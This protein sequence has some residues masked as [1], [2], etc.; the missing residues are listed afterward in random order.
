MGVGPSRGP[1]KTR[2]DTPLVVISDAHIK[3]VIALPAPMM[4][5]S[6]EVPLSVEKSSNHDDVMIIDPVP[7]ITALMTSWVPPTSEWMSAPTDQPS[8]QN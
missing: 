3:P 4:L 6:F 7:T 5:P 8:A 1:K 2:P